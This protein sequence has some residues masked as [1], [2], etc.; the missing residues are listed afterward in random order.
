MNEEAGATRRDATINEQHFANERAER[1]L[2]NSAERTTR[3][4]A[5]IN[6][7]R[8]A[9]RASGAPYGC[10]KMVAPLMNSASRC[11]L[12]VPPRVFEN[13]RSEC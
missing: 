6:E 3:S 11:E 8:F 12:L 7:Q 13:G 1:L 9:L 5:T 4:R 10:S 2:M